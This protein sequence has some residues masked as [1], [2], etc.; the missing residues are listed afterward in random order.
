MDIVSIAKILGDSKVR[1]IKFLHRGSRVT[2]DS[3]DCQVDTRGLHFAISFAELIRQS[4]VPKSE[5]PNVGAVGIPEEIK[6][7]PFFAA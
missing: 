4:G 1:S 2:L 7:G 3:A 5:A 6:R